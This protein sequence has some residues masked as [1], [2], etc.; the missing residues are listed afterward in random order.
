[1]EPRSA[2]APTSAAER[3]KDIGLWIIGTLGLLALTWFLVSQ[4]FGLTVIT[5]RTGSMTP[6]YPQGAAAVSIP[7]D[8]ADLEVGDVVTVE[9]EGQLPITHRIVDIRAAEDPS[10]RT[11][12]MQGDDNDWPDREPYT[13]G[14]VKRVL[15]GLPGA[16]TALT[17]MQ[18]PAAFGVL[19]V[20]LAAL[21]TWGL[22]P[23]STQRKT[24]EAE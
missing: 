16:G 17:V 2:A 12:T 5:F 10:Q 9:R 4:L 21:I 7:T 13:V 15:F 6:T 11:I 14:E 24:Q 23:T 19:T 1:M 18:T 22:W 3:S 20:G 8:A